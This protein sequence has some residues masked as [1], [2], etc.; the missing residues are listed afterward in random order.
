MCSDSPNNDSYRRCDRDER[1]PQDGCSSRFILHR[2]IVASPW[3]D[4]LRV[5]TEDRPVVVLV[6]WSGAV[7]RFL[8]WDF[9]SC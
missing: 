1:G 2:S 3:P 8:P 7:H 9:E 5:S 4:G 6:I